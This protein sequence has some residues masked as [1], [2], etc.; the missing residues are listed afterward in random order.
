MGVE[1]NSSWRADRQLF[2][3]TR[4]SCTVIPNISVSN[5]TIAGIEV[6]FSKGRSVPQCVGQFADQSATLS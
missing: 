4:R 2:S 1:F 3:V 5:R 6:D